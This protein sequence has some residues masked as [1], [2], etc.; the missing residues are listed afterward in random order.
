[1]SV[2]LKNEMDVFIVVQIQS[3]VWQAVAS[4][5]DEQPVPSFMILDIITQEV[6]VLKKIMQQAVFK[7]QHYWSVFHV[8]C[9]V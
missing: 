7:W 8:E 6:A 5:S 3:A 9:A 1:M 2:V 4:I